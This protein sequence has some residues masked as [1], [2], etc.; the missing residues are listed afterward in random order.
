MYSVS[1]ASN[2]ADIRIG[3]LEGSLQREVI[4]SFSIGDSTATGIV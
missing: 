1:E 2:R 4:V 3:V